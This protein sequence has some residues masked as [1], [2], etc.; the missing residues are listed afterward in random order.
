MDVMRG[1]NAD[2]RAVRRFLAEE[3]KDTMLTW[4]ATGHKGGPRWRR[5]GRDHRAQFTADPRSYKALEEGHH[6][7]LHQRVENRKSR[8]VKSNQHS[9]VR[10]SCV[11]SRPDASPEV[12]LSC[13]WMK[14]THSP[15]GR[16]GISRCPTS[17]KSST[18]G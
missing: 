2:V 3:I 1:R 6:P 12:R 11:P 14:A 18:K 9:L 13:R 16:S 8:S 10:H 17:V 5:Q 15:T 4:T 7:I